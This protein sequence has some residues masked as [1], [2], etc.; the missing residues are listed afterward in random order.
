MY[1]FIHISEKSYVQKSVV[2]YTY[3][4]VA[5]PSSLE[6]AKMSLTIIITQAKYF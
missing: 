3:I 1:Y 4:I 2:I 6:V 5:A